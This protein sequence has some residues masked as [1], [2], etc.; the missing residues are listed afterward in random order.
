MSLQK[1]ERVGFSFEEDDISVGEFIDRFTQ[2]GHHE[3]P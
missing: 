1:I 2:S 3:C